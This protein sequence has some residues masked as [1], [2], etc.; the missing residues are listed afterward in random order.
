[1]VVSR[2]A[3]A[4]PVQPCVLLLR[5][6][7]IVRRNRV[8]MAGLREALSDLGRGEIRTYLQSGNVILEPIGSLEELPG[9]VEARVRD[10][11]GVETAVLVRQA[12]ELVPLLGSNPFVAA[13]R[14]EASLHVT[15]L[16]AEPAAPEVPGDFG[17]DE[18]AVVGREVYLYCPAGYARSRLGNAYLE[19][20]LGVAA[21]T[22]NWRTVRSVAQMLGVSPP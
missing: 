7:N 9:L 14:D 21:T 22:R 13:G 2:A 15:F 20:V 12:R 1:L 4:E 18:V 6:I 10:T 19:R 16:A 8:P 3:F 11:F 5:A 17:H